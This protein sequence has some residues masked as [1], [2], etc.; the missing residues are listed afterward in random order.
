VALVS[1]RVGCGSPVAGLTV[2]L[3]RYVPTFH[4]RTVKAHLQLFRLRGAL[5]HSSTDGRMSTTLAATTQTKNRM[6]LG[7]AEIETNA[8]RGVGVPLLP[9]GRLTEQG[10]HDGG[11]HRE[12]RN[13]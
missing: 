8:E 4:P 1:S 10:E 12:R 6:K 7:G 9:T 3:L 11:D 13:G 5:H 2:R